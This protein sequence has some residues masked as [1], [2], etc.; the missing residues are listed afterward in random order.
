MARYRSQDKR[1]ETSIFKALLE[2]INDLFRKIGSET[3]SK[4][5]IPAGTDYPDSKVYNKLISNIG[6]DIDKLF[7]AQK[8]IESDI[9]NLIN[10]NSNQRIR[11]YENLTTAQQE[12]YS[13]YTKSKRDTIGGVEIPEGT[14]FSSSDNM[15]SESIDVYIDESRS[16]LTLAFESSEERSLDIKNTTIYFAGKLPERPIYPL[17]NTL[18]IGSHWKKATNDPHF[19]NTDDPSSVD[20]YKTMMIDDPN[21]NISVGFSEFEAV[22]TAAYNYIEVTDPSKTRLIVGY[23]S[24]LIVSI[25]SQTRSENSS[26][27]ILK[28]YIG[29]KY[30]KD[31]EL[32]YID[33]PNSLQGQFVASAPIKNEP[34]K[35]N[36]G[37]P[38]Y[39]LV[40]PFT[41]QLLTNELVVDLAANVNGFIP[42]INWT[43]S[44]VFS[45]VAG[46]DIA[47]S[48]IPPNEGKDTFS[49]GKFVVHISS[50]V[51]PT[52]ME[53]IIEYDN[54]ELMWIPFDFYMSHYVYSD[55]K[56]YQMP[57]NGDEKINITI[58]KSYDIFV[59][60]EA[61]STKEG[62]RAIGVLRSP[63]RSSV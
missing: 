43:E 29:Q 1:T 52:R 61:N 5:D 12:V 2:E 15:S 23:S 9:N 54:D 4:R 20:N 48:L 57:F 60:A 30:G 44:K 16:V 8:I 38:K 28:H 36:S 63:N 35:P 59:D 37:T 50:F 45:K 18:G 40:V 39:K 27:Y 3:S 19:I 41:S 10:F 24:P 32:I 13:A 26:V 31:P 22:R 6:F 62:N 34:Y 7:N 25:A 17:G 33:L 11:T 58:K 53:L 49:D 56:T 21:S 14:P 46:N 47:Y 55:Q 51:I 42:K